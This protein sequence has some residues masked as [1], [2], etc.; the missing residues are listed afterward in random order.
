MTVDLQGMMEKGGLSL[1]P[2]FQGLKLI[3]GSQQSHQSQMYKIR[4]Q[5]IIFYNSLK[6]FWQ[7]EVRLDHPQVSQLFHNYFLALNITKL[8]V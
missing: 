5:E 7:Q 4:A 2:V 8:N 1:K 6:I 3:K